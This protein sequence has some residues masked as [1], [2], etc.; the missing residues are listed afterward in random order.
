MSNYSALVVEINNIRPHENADRLV[1][2]SICGNN[3]IVGKDTQVGDVGL[4]FPLE[5]QL[6]EEFAKANDLIR[7]KDENGKPAGGMFD[8]N[9]RVRAQKFRG[10]KSMGFFCPL[11]YLYN[12]PGVDEDSFSLK[13]GDEI[14]TL[15][16]YD[17]SKKYIIPGNTQSVAGK[18]G[19][20]TKKESRIIP[21]QFHFH[22]DTAQL[23]RN[24]HKIE[25][26][27]LISVTWKFHGT[28]GIVGNVLVKKKQN[29][30]QKLLTKLFGV[31]NT[32]YDYIYASRRVVKNDDKQYNH[33][34][35]FDIWGDAG[36][37][38]KG[39]LH[40]GEQVYYE[41]VGYLPNGGEIQKGYDYG[42]EKGRYDVY[43]YRITM[44]NPEGVV[45]ELPWHQVK[46]RAKELGVKTCPE[47]YYGKAAGFCGLPLDDGAFGEH[48]YAHLSDHYVYDQKSIFCKNSVPEEGVVVRVENGDGI[49]NYKDKAFAFL[50]HE[51]KQLDKGE[52]D[53][54]SA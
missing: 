1:C 33:F 39:L 52:K 48:L 35:N 22:F 42:C 30:F 8:Q 29:L 7:R 47:I 17:I 21:E 40:Q 16:G 18:K 9:R 4:F 43:V 25:P 54:E 11:S 10:E 36:S 3:V 46:H 12:L 23:G 14:E 31:P 26:N 53:L 2:T 15:G 49:E 27:S 19:K 45:T 51:T 41:I 24:M 28:S 37:K 20:K 50:S 44:T 6:G 34:Y 38:F 32:E 5:S 13:P